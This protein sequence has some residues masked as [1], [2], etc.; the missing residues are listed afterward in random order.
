[1]AHNAQPYIDKSD[2]S[3]AEIDGFRRQQAQSYLDNNDLGSLEQMIMYLFY[4]SPFYEENSNNEQLRTQQ[5][6]QDYKE[7]LQNMTGV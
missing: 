7:Q 3:F 2:L 6:F 1:M 4:Q 5:V